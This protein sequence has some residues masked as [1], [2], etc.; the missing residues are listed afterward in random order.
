MPRKQI[1]KK[2]LIFS[3]FFLSF[4]CQTQPKDAVSVIQITSDPIF[5]CIRGVIFVE[6]KSG[7]SWLPK[8]DGRPVSCSEFEVLDF[9]PAEDV[10][11]AILKEKPG[12]KRH[13]R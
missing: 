5:T 13:G 4:G 3:A 9:V 6:K 2:S 1:F 10:P 12:S 8:P 11:D 7:F